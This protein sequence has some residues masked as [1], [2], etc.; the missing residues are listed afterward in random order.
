MECTCNKKTIRKDEE[1]KT[2]KSRLNKIEGQIRGISNMV[3]DDRYCDDI[4]IHKIFS[5]FNTRKTYEIMR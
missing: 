1:K 3:D 5:K 4:Q 2:I